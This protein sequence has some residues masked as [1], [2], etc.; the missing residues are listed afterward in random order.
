MP[1]AQVSG[2]SSTNRVWLENRFIISVEYQ[3]YK[4]NLVSDSNSVNCIMLCKR[5]FCSHT[6]RYFLLISHWNQDNIQNPDSIIV[7][8]SWQCPREFW[9][10]GNERYCSWYLFYYTLSNFHYCSWEMK[11][12]SNQWYCPYISWYSEILM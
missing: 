4:L 11:S 1:R 12:N 9:F 3:E 7:P 6:Y 8:R 10:A 2:K 5:W